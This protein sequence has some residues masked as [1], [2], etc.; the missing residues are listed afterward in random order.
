MYFAG[1]RDRLDGVCG[2][3]H[4]VSI[5]GSW[6][7]GHGGNEAACSSFWDRIGR[8][9]FRVGHADVERGVFTREVS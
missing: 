7:G 9:E 8:I 4:A 5:R 3:E 1:R 2:R 6:R